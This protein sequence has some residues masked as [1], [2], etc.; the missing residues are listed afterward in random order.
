MKCLSCTGSNLIKY[1]FN[2]YVLLIGK[3]RGKVSNIPLSCRRQR[4]KIAFILLKM[5]QSGSKI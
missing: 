3:T 1:I 4:R 5:C 2:R